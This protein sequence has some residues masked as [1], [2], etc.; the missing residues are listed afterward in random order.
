MK[1]F[2]LAAFLFLFI[3]GLGACHTSK[4]LA[5]DSEPFRTLR[6]ELNPTAAVLRIADTIKVIYPEAAMFD[7]GKDEIKSDVKPKLI[8]FAGVLRNYPDI[9]I[10]VNGY[11]DNVG[12]DELNT[13]LS[14]RRAVNAYNLLSD[15]GVDAARMNTAGFGPQNP[16][17]S[18]ED[19]AGR[20]ANRRVEFM[21]YRQRK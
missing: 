6:A 4:K 2:S 3:A 21:L 10:L 8:R 7:F 12:P 20:A 1:N 11:T 13:A 16:L 9:R 15:N 14:R 17:Q 18:N 19:E 5:D